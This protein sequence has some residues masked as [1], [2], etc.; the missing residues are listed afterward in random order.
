MEIYLV[1]GAVR[2]KLLGLPVKER[3][4]VVLG[5]T[6]ESMIKQGYRP[7]GKDFPVFLHPKTHEEYAL[8]RTER[9]TAPGYK[10]FIIHAAPDVSLEQDLIRR[11]LTINAMAMTPKGQLIDPYNGQIDLEKRIFRHISP[12]F[13]EDPVRILRIARFA[14]RYG[15]LGFTLAEETRSLMQSMV[16]AGE[17]DHLVPERVW[18]ELFKA[19][20]EKSPSAFF[21]TLKA[22]TA[23]DKIFP[24]IQC[25]FGVPQPEHSH[26]EIDTGIHVMLCLEQAALMSASPE[27]R[28]AALVHDLGKGVTPRTNWPHHYGHETQGLRILEQLCMRLRVPNSFKTLA[29]QVMQYHT[30]CH[31]AF[32]LRASTITDMLAAL[33]AYKPRHKL[34]EFLQA[35]EADAK[36]RTGF[37]NT[38]YPQAILLSGAAKAA[39]SVDTSSILNGDLKGSHIGEAIRRLRIK[40]V[41][42]F[43]KAESASAES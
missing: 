42:E 3:D 6:P 23:L 36:G 29:M 11:D 35:C 24:E 41:A 4:W 14:A 37:E 40:A 17:V 32:E 22:C 30:H 16:T 39:A 20:N 15:H 34:S 7:V 2:D 13:A 33:G 10:G 43:I 12:A 21:Y 5:E 27:V 19:L 31:R 18:A 9:K 25:L 1:G 28:F 26:P 8:A 38:P